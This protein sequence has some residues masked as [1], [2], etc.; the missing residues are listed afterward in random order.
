MSLSAEVMKHLITLLLNLVIVCLTD[1]LKYI[2]CSYCTRNEK[3][4]FFKWRQEETVPVIPTLTSLCSVWMEQ[5]SSTRVWS[6]HVCIL[7]YFIFQDISNYARVSQRLT[8]KFKQPWLW[9]TSLSG[10][11]WAELM[12]WM[13]S[14]TVNRSAC[15]AHSF[16]CKNHPAADMLN[17]STTSDCSTQTTSPKY[18]KVFSA[19]YRLIV[20]LIASNSE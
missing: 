18:K 20:I 19:Q 6:S 12:S 15:G 9:R 8:N 3:L 4:S 17:I 14:S 10:R 16:L 1:H 2:Y 11:R 13:S 5:R 7:R